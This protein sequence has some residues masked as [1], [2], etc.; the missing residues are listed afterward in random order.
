VT[1]LCQILPILNFQDKMFQVHTQNNTNQII[2]F[3]WCQ[4]R[5]CCENIFSSKSIERRLFCVSAVF[6][7]VHNKYC[8]RQ[9]MWD[10]KRRKSIKTIMFMKMIGRKWME[11]SEREFYWRLT[12]IWHEGL[13]E[14]N[15]TLWKFHLCM[16]N[17]FL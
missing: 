4:K 13:Q 14:F 16:K 10:E 5:V 7:F 6:T 1:H 15:F 9:I 11:T 17:L 8:E 2:Y 3:S 12:E